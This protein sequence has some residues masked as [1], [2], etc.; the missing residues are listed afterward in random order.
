MLTFLF[1]AAVV[2]AAAGV[3]AGTLMLWRIPVPA[4][5]GGTLEKGVADVTVIIPARN[6]ARRIRPLLESLRRQTVQP[7]EILVVDDASTDDTA[8]IAASYGAEVLP[9]KEL[10]DGWTGKSAACWLGAQRAAGERLLFLDADTVLREKNSLH[11]IRSAFDGNGGRGLL[12]VQ[13]YH[14]M[15]EGYEYLSA[16]FNVIVMAGMNVFTPRGTALR[17]AG[18]FGPCIMC[19]G[20]DYFAAGGHKGV[21]EAVMDDLELGAAFRRSGFPVFCY[22]G[23]GI[24]DFRMYPEG[25]RSLVEGWTK[26]FGTA[27]QATH[28]FVT[29]LISL[30]ISGGMAGMLLPF[31]AILFP[32]PGWTA[33]A[34]AA[35]Y[36]VYVIH[37]AWLAR[38]TGTF[39]RWIFLFF[40]VLLLFFLGL[41]LWSLYLTNVRGTVTWRGR[42]INV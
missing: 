22:G 37:T 23:R 25:F 11:R 13:P 4:E 41:F 19:S 27:S 28:P 7:L 8:A 2:L 33:V 14:V 30:W 29:V 9:S 3:A 15:Y 5:T 36:G 32:L 39:P 10:E 1:G 38:R 16:W 34:A 40:P 21:R 42:K 26:N 35:V 20:S 6:E 17:E 12:S 24:I 18:S 31:A